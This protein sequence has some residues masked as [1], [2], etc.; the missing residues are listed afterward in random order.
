MIV[1]TLRDITDRKKATAR[2][3]EAEEEIRSRLAEL[4]RS[5][6][7]LEQLAYI[8]SHDL[9]E[10]LRTVASYTQ[11]LERRYAHQLD[12]DARDSWRTSWAGPSA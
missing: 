6:Q 7:E 1:A 3:L 10:P 4:T 8:T 2:M 9:S 5:N 11:L 12:K